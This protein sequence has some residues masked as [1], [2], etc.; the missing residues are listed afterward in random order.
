VCA[1]VR[2]CLPLLILNQGRKSPDGYADGNNTHKRDV[3]VVLASGT[4]VM[5]VDLNEVG[6]ANV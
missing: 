6:S 5:L 2:S 3:Q 4:W 1:L